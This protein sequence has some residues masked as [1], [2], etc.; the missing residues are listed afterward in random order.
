MTQPPS[1]SRSV[2]N[3]PVERNTSRNAEYTAA[4]GDTCANCGHTG[5]LHWASR[6]ASHLRPCHVRGCTCRTFLP[7]SIA[8]QFH[9]TPSPDGQSG[10]RS[11]GVKPAPRAPAERV[12]LDA[13]AERTEYHAGDGAGASQQ[14]PALNVHSGQTAAWSK[15]PRSPRANTPCERCWHAWAV[16]AIP[17]RLCRSKTCSCPRFLGSW[18]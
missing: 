13:A 18:E 6:M 4:T 14:F 11:G 7:P 2:I 8:A 9:P 10:E 12:W 15:R 16:H 5:N 1:S 3:R 17:G